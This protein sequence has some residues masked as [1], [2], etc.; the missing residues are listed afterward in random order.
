MTSKGK[1]PARRPLVV[2]GGGGHAKVLLHTLA[3]RGEFQVLGYVDPRDHGPLSG[4]KRLGGDEVLPQLA[5][6]RN[7]AAAIGVGKVRAGRSRLKVLEGL[8]ELGFALPPVIAVSAVVAGDARLGEATV[9]LDGAVVQPGCAIGA[10]AIVNTNATVDHDCV[11]GDDVH[12]ASGAVLS[13]GVSVGDGSLVGAGASL[14]Q[15]VRVGADVTIGA[16]A[17]VTRDCLESGTYVGV[18][19]RRLGR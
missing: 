17:A 10:G 12:V 4:F 5:K 16:G 1:K 11:L 9:V 15:G 19:A 2:I 3:L 14:V 7:V 18:P 8:R 6:K 13:G